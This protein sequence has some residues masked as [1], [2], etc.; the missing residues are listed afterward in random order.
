MYYKIFE[1]WIQY[2]TGTFI[3][4][5]FKS[6]LIFYERRLGSRKRHI[7]WL[8]RGDSPKYWTCLL[9]AYKTPLTTTMELKMTRMQSFI[10][11]PYTSCEEKTSD[12]IILVHSPFRS[13]RG[14]ERELKENH[15]FR[16]AYKC[17]LKMNTS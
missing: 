14:G 17:L 10:T 16:L 15:D 1:G 13:P 8:A 7:R 4:I 5:S 2:S 12:C 6:I 9:R 11:I 3:T